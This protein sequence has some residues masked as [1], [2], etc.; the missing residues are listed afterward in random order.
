MKDYGIPLRKF[1]VENFKI[2]E[3]IDF[4]D[5]QIFDN[6]ITYTGIFSFLKKIENKYSFEYQKFYKIET[7]IDD[8]RL[9]FQSKTSNEFKKVQNVNND[10]LIEDSWVFNNVIDSQIFSKI[11]NKEFPKLKQISK[12]VFQGVATGKD[13]VFFVNKKIKEENKLEEELCIPIYKGKDIRKF[14]ANW[15]GTYIIYPYNKK[16]NKVFNEVEMKNNYPNIFLY[17]IDNKKFLQG[18]DYFNNSNKLWYELWCERNFK[19]FNQK[20]IINC[21]IS[22]ENRFYLDENNFFGNTKIFSTVL[23]DEYSEFYLTLLGILNSK[24]LNYYHKKIASPKAGGFYDYKTQYIKKY[25]ISFPKKTSDFDSLVTKI[26]SLKST[27]TPSIYFENKIDALVFH[28]YGLT[29]VEMNQVLDTFKDLDTKH[30][31]QIINEYDNISNN[32][33]RVDL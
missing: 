30:R 8:K 26:L 19:K 32:T 20:K 13:E 3:I 22:P 7:K 5:Y 23:K 6:A 29:E 16:T 31:T 11:E 9:L 24:I 12:Y 27:N 4:G 17:L 2:K 21:E 18:R 10:K 25:P 14:T 15:S 33:F 1:I 28:L